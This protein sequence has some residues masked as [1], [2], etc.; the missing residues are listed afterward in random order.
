MDVYYTQQLLY[1]V[2]YNNKKGTSS[3]FVSFL[4]YFVLFFKANRDCICK[5]LLGICMVKR[6]KSRF[7]YE[8]DQIYKWNG[9]SSD[10]MVIKANYSLP[11]CLSDF[12]ISI[13]ILCFR[14]FLYLKGRVCELIKYLKSK[15]KFC[16]TFK[17]VVLENVMGRYRL[18]L[19]YWD[20]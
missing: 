2:Y 1:D 16:E 14:F 7:V 9:T 17:F 19:Q 4:L 20:D 13:G 11:F 12:L 18:V 8:K 5:H 10:W 15:G 6:G 3:P